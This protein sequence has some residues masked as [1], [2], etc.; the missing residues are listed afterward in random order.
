LPPR[1]RRRQ[2]EF[3]HIP[4]RRIASLYGP[5]TCAWLIGDLYL[6]DRRRRIWPFV[7]R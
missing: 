5:S 2:V 7:P 3:G 4:R 1:R 6:V